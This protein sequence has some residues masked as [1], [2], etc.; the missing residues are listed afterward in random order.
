LEVLGVRRASTA[1]V[2]PLMAMGLLRDLAA[3]LR[4]TSRFDAL[5]PAMTHPEAQQLLAQR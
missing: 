4:A 5:N 1:T 3:Q 2:L